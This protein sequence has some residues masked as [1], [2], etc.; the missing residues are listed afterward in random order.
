MLRYDPYA[1]MA[2]A[3]MQDRWQWAARARLRRSAQ[4]QHM[5]DEP[6]PGTTP[7]P[8]GW[9]WRLVRLVRGTAPAALEAGD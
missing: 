5:P 8:G 3:E 4:G 1:S 7:H 6:I 2:R 9:L